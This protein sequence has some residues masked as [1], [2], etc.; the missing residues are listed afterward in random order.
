MP[1]ARSVEPAS[2]PRRRF[3]TINDAAEYLCVTERTIRLM[4]SDGRLVGYRLN[5]RFIRLDLDEINAAMQPFGGRVTNG[6]GAH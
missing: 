2:P 6:N 5:D 4:I 1:A 3:I